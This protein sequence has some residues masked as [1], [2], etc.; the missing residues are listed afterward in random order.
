M[1]SHGRLAPL[2]RDGLAI[3]FN[4]ENPNEL[5]PKPLTPHSWASEDKYRHCL[6]RVKS[7]ATVHTVHRTSK[8]IIVPRLILCQQHSCFSTLPQQH[9]VPMSAKKQTGMAAPVFDLCW[10]DASR[11][12]HG[13]AE[14]GFILPLQLW[15]SGHSNTCLNSVPAEA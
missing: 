10:Q 13:P 6:H 8:S 1:D 9:W 12:P 3:Y 14:P 15:S 4:G 5:F 7:G 11:E 2:C